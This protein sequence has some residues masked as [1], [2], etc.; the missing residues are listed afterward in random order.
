ME[1]FFRIVLFSLWSQRARRAHPQL[2]EVAIL[3]H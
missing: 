3:K 2:Y 1:L